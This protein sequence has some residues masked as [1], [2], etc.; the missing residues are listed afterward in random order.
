M[1]RTVPQPQ[2]DATR[3]MRWILWLHN[4]LNRPNNKL[5][6]SAPIQFACHSPM[7]M[8]AIADAAGLRRLRSRW[9]LGS[10]RLLQLMATC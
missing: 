7:T 6:G 1:F 9:V 5:S 3:L 2:S 8:K 4:H 10:R